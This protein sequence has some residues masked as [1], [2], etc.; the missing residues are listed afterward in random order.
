M[1]FVLRRAVSRATI[2]RIIEWAAPQLF[3]SEALEPCFMMF[4]MVCMSDRQSHGISTAGLPRLFCL[5]RLASSRVRAVRSPY[6][7]A[8]KA[9]ISLAFC[10]DVSVYDSGSLADTVA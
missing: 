7:S 5:F 1:L 8:R 9:P 3:L 2:A 10:V 4:S 6:A